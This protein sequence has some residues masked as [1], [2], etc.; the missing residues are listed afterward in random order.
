MM[1]R[2]CENSERLLVLNYFCENDPSQTFNRVLNLS[3]LRYLYLEL[4]RRKK[5]PYLEFFWSV[6]SR[7]R[8]EYGDLQSLYFRTQ[9]EYG[10][11]RI[12]KAPNTDTF[13]AVLSQLLQ[14][15]SRGCTSGKKIVNNNEDFN[16]EGSKD[17]TKKAGCNILL[18]YSYFE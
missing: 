18:T 14:L 17:K 12:R 13:Y 16:E 8:T 2:F 1:R 6:F 10:K 7:I 11:I 3:L 15:L 4:R 9:S 5:C